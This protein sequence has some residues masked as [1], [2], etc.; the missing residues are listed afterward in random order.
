MLDGHQ[1]WCRGVRVHSWAPGRSRL[2]VR[3]SRGWLGI[4][5]GLQPFDSF[6]F[7]Q[8]GGSS[9]NWLDVGDLT[10]AVDVDGNGPVA[11]PE[12]SAQPQQSERISVHATGAHGISVKARS[13]KGP[14]SWADCHMPSLPWRSV[15]STT[16]FVVPSSTD[17][18]SSHVGPSSQRT[19]PRQPL[20]GPADISR[21]RRVR[22][23]CGCRRS[24]T[25]RLSRL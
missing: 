11:A 24:V 4:R 15:P 19:Q 1:Q 23:Q 12:E 2:P 10:V 5:E 3:I 9:T 6:A 7:V 25:G 8:S 13:R 14:V 18:L 16:I 22:R 20:A 17:A 21:R